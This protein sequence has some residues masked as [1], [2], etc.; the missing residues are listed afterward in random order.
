MHVQVHRP[1]ICE[2]CKAEMNPIGAIGWFRCIICGT[3]RK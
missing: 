3:L 1:V 2:I